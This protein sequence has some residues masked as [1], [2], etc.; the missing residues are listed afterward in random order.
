MKYVPHE[1]QRYAIN[2]I[3]EQ[4]AAGLFLDM[5]LGKTV[6]ALTAIN[7][8]LYNY[9]AVSNVLVIAPLRVAQT[10]LA[11]GNSKMGSFAALN[12]LKNIGKWRRKKSSSQYSS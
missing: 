12:Y 1:Y 9:F 7:E 8:L 6:I 11:R 5:G 3:L 10:T 4:D 2:K